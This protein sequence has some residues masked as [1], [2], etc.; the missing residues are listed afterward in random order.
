MRMGRV[1]Q[2]AHFRGVE[3][4]SALHDAVFEVDDARQND[5]DLV[6]RSRQGGHGGGRGAESLD[7]SRKERTVAP[8][9]ADSSAGGDDRD[10]RR[11][12]VFT[13]FE[14]DAVNVA[15]IPD[16]GD[17]GFPVA[18]DIRLGAGQEPFPRQLEM[19]AALVRVQFVAV[20]EEVC[21]R[22]HQRGRQQAGLAIGRG[23]G[24]AAN[25]A[26]DAVL[27]IEHEGAVAMQHGA[28]EVLPGLDFHGRSYW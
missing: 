3:L 28:V 13:Q 17:P 11:S 18:F 24:A 9:P 15:G 22:L 12:G 27:D 2:F 25:A 26:A 7:F 8:R 4:R 21:V 19:G 10:A 6:D 5:L 23:R 14:I 20:Q 16:D 1:D